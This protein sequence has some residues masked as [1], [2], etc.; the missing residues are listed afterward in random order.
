MEFQE[1]SQ[2][3]ILVTPSRELNLCKCRDLPGAPRNPYINPCPDQLFPPLFSSNAIVCDLLLLYPP[4]VRGNLPSMRQ[5]SAGRP[6]RLPPFLTLFIVLKNYLAVLTAVKTAKTL[7]FLR[8]QYLPQA[9]FSRLQTW[10]MLQEAMS[11]L[12]CLQH[13]EVHSRFTRAEAVI[14]YPLP[15]PLQTRVQSSPMKKKKIPHTPS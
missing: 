15:Q 3:A 9:V 11:Q 6:V 12:S 2:F 8:L 5:A 10:V 4:N 14:I 7:K 1:L 13:S